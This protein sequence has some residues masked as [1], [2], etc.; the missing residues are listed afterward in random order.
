VA[1]LLYG[2]GGTWLPYSRKLLKYITYICAKFVNIT[3]ILNMIGALGPLN[4]L[5]QALPLGKT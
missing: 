2:K 5:S 4:N 1:E 3:Q